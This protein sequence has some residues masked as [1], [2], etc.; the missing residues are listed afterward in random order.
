MN[1]QRCASLSLATLILM[2]LFAAGCQSAGNP[3]VSAETPDE[4]QIVQA[5]QVVDMQEAIPTEVEVIEQVPE[6]P[7]AAEPRTL[8][9]CQGTEPDSNFIYG[10]DMLA[11]ANIHQM[12]YDGS[13]TN[14][15]DNRSFDFQAV[16]WEKTPSLADGDALL[17]VVT[18]SEGDTVVDADGNVALLDAAADPP[19]L[20][21]PAGGTIDD[22][23]AYESGEVELDQ[24]QVT[25]VLKP[26]ITWSD[27]TPVT[28]ADS[29]YTFNVA[30]DPASSASK[31]VTERTTSYRAVDDLTVVWTG[32]PGYKDATYFINAWQPL[33]EHQLGQY[34]VLE[35]L[36]AEESSRTPMGFGPYNIQDWVAGDSITL[37][38]NPTY[39]RA[40]EGL[41]V[42]DTV[43]FRFVGGDSDANIAALLSG[44]CDIIAQTSGLDDE[45]ERMLELHD[46]GQLNVTF[47]TGTVWAHLDFGIQHVD[48][49]DGY[50]KGTD[51]PD[52]F[53]DVRIRRAFALCLDRQAIVDHFTLGQSIV[54][55]SYIPPQH[56]YY[57]PDVTH[58]SFDVS[59]GIALLEEV[60]WLDH[61]EDATTPRIAS[62]V[63]NVID[64]TELII[65]MNLGSTSM[66]EQAGAIIQESLA[67]CGIQADFIFYPLDEY[68]G[69]GPVGILFGRKFDLSLSAW[70]T[71]VQ[72][73]CDLYL[74][75]QTPGPGGES[76]T[77]IMT[78]DDIIFQSAWGGQN[79]PGFADQAYD[80]ACNLA[81]QSFLGQPENKIA[82]LEAQKI[83]SEQLP[84]IPLYLF[85][86]MAATRPDM[87]NF[88]I[89]PTE[90]SEFWNIEEFDYG[91]G[92]EE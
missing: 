16:I 65:S 19:V 18:A 49:D 60:G 63:R 3:E 22:A 78:G 41:P 62:N 5:T 2:V 25:F 54:V 12:I 71:G 52:F 53:S 38:K 35:L 28:A 44:E 80:A 17:N 9:I 72:P 74:S 26:G 11:S 58:Y 34:T 73:P 88:I 81:L 40:D 32:L 10:S 86:K 51:R 21:V 76:M 45:M 20:L 29:V 89:D 47:S 4:T 69:D 84:V 77:S 82:N 39:F 24:M 46:S 8:V 59:S 56:P 31:Y 43:I 83:F 50:Q 91:E 6:T 70:L 1:I 7:E 61:D 36:E 92:C 37:V 75:S 55:D 23:F 66:G 42:F 68:Y 48:Y 64:G 90:N 57:N 87:C 30:S 85:I 33:P 14:G 67:Q 27:G 15:F 79:N 13:N